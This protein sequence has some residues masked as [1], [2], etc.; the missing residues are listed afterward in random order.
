MKLVETIAT[1]ALIIGVSVTLAV[2]TINHFQERT[3]QIKTE[4]LEK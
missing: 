3:T 4:E 2:A 1:I